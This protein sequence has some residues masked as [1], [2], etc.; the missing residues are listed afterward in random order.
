MNNNNKLFWLTL[1]K[2]MRNRKQ[3]IRLKTFQL[4]ISSLKKDNQEIKSINQC[5]KFKLPQ[6]I[7]WRYKT[8]QNQ[9]FKNFRIK[10][11]NNKDLQ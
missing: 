8:I 3:K 2:A 5:S 6:I 9:E 4:M 10:V 11:E 7:I 1:Y